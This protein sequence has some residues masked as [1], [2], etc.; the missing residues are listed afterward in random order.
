MN[1]LMMH[2]VKDNN[3]NKKLRNVVEKNRNIPFQKNTNITC[4]SNI[5]SLTEKII[6]V[7]VYSSK[8]S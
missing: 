5:F 1:H 4:L 3:N 2:H 8:K 7:S 6:P